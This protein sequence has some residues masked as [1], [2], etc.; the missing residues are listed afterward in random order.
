MLGSPS[1]PRQSRFARFVSSAAAVTGLNAGDSS[2]QQ[3]GLAR[4]KASKLSGKDGSQSELTQPTA[5][6]LSVT[7]SRAHVYSTLHG[8][9][10]AFTHS[11]DRCNKHDLSCLALPIN[12]HRL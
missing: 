10:T 3:E 9:Y 8:V 11:C 2:A 5:G 1:P 7:A 12:T 4:E 6:E